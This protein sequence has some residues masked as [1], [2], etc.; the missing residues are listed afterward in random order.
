MKSTA[1]NKVYTL[2]KVGV[3]AAVY[4]VATVL[5]SPLSYGI[6]QFR[7]SEVLML[8]CCYKPD[9]CIALS[10]GC[11]ISNLFSPT[12]VFDVPIGTAATVISAVLMYKCKNL[13]ISALIC[14]IVNA[15]LV[16]FE[17]TFVFNEPFFISAS[18]VFLGQFVVVFIIGAAIFKRI[19]NKTVFKQYIGVRKTKITKNN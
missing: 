5:I 8:L 15:V 11:F 14:S 19:E 1:K 18:S 16:G 6:V 9:F 17:L 7:F 4:I 13:Y 3:I 10:L 2:T 12:A